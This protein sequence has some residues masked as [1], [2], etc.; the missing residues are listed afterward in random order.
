[1]IRKGAVWALS[2]DSEEVRAVAAQ[3]RTPGEWVI[4]GEGRT[5]VSGISSG[6]VVKTTDAV[7][8]VV[9]AVRQAEEASRSSC[10]R[11]FYGYDDSG[12]IQAHPMGS[13]T[14]S[15]EGQIQRNDVREAA[16]HAQRLVGDY[17]RIP[18][19]SREV[20]YLIDGKDAVGNPFGVFGHKLD[21][22]L[23]IILSR[24]THYQAWKKV[25]ERAGFSDAIPV[26]SLV[27]SIQSVTSRADGPQILWDLGEDL[28]SGGVVERGSLREYVVFERKQKDAPSL[29]AKIAAVNE[30]WRK[31]DNRLSGE[32]RLTGELGEAPISADLARALGP[33]AQWRSPSGIGSLHA[34][35]DAAL[36]GLLM[37]AQ[38]SARLGV[39]RMHSGLVAEARSRVQDLIKEY[40]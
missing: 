22:R 24:A 3:E 21:V 38:E 19:Y 27:G 15:G 35:K 31:N 34:R 29:A 28:C 17:E 11:L 14:L 37:L 12:M 26:L 13:K 36:A 23:H 16:A 20:L 9:A 39:S 30:A 6:A 33:D 4:L 40:F 1:M 8:S 10:S 7:E 5:R 18:V 32:C 2:V 25:M